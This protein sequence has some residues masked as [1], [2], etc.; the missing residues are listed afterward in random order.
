MFGLTVV[1]GFPEDFHSACRACQ[2]FR[3]THLLQSDFTTLYVL[4]T[5]WFSGS[6]AALSAV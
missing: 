3:F 4:S 1:M 6:F 5:S 2:L